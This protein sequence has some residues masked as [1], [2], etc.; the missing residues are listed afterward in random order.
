MAQTIALQRGEVT[1][2]SNTSTLLFT[3]TSSG[4]STRVIVGYLSYNSDFAN[5]SGYCTFSVLRSGEVSPNFSIFGAASPGNAA[6]SV[7]LS[8]HNVRTG[9]HGVSNSAN[10]YTPTLNNTTNAGLIQATSLGSG[11]LKAFYNSDVMLGPSDAVYCSWFD[12]GGGS[13]A[14]IVQYCFVLVTE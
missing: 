10:D 7:T 9:W 12:N 3:N 5:V 11:G 6:K 14:A 4:T 2:T 1:M 13:R 8:P